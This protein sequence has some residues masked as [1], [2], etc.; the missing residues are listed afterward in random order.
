[1]RVLLVLSLFLVLSLLF[2]LPALGND[3]VLRRS[4]P[5]AYTGEQAKEISTLRLTSAIRDSKAKQ[6]ILVREYA[7]VVNSGKYNVHEVVTR[8]RDGYL[9]EV[10]IAVLPFAGPG[11]KLRLYIH[12]TTEGKV[13]S[14]KDFVHH[15]VTARHLLTYHREQVPIITVVRRNGEP[16]F[17]SLIED[18]LCRE[19]LYLE[20]PGYDPRVTL[21][22]L[23]KKAATR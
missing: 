23:E 4:F 8:Y 19:I 15:L 17:P 14:E 21:E 16:Y 1:M 10:E 5:Q 20:Q 6:A 11:N 18:I 22:S 12:V 13:S 7:E 3:V 9:E 2:A